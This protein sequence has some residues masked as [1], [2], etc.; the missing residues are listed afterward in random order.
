MEFWDRRL[1]QRNIPNGFI[2]KIRQNFQ[3]RNFCGVPVQRKF[4]NPKTGSWIPEFEILN[5][6]FFR[7]HKWLR[8]TIDNIKS[9]LRL[10]SISGW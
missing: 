5:S 6:I 1:N 9:G 3:Q 8:Q 4:R 2:Q 7:S 10:C